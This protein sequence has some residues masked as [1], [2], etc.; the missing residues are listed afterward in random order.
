MSDLSFAPH[1]Q[2]VLLK[3]ADQITDM[4]ETF[5]LTDTQP[6]TLFVDLWL[7]RHNRWDLKFYN[8]GNQTVYTLI[9][10]LYDESSER[11]KVRSKPGIKQILESDT[12]TKVTFDV[13]DLAAIMACDHGIKVQGFV[14]IQLM[15]LA[16][17]FEKDRWKRSSINT[18]E[19]CVQDAARE[20]YWMSQKPWRLELFPALYETYHRR[21]RENQTDGEFWMAQVRTQTGERVKAATT[22]GELDPGNDELYNMGP[23]AWYGRQL[24]DQ[25]AAWSERIMKRDGLEEVMPED[26]YDQDDIWGH[27][28]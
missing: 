21:F 19:K 6:P 8:T 23:W 4:L 17:S 10:D 7:A 3:T 5:D 26:V 2:A 15:E 1:T 22:V 18:F 14:D 25:R 16:S 28:L 20:F 11:T 13:R 12:I 9:F 27:A 24:R